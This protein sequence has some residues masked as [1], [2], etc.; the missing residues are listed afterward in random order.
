VQHRIEELAREA[1]ELLDTHRIMLA[2]AESCTGGWISQSL[3]SVAGSSAWFERGFVTYSNAAKEEMLG[4][5]ATTLAN[6]GAVSEDTALAMARGAVDRSRAHMSVAV[7]G[8]AGPTGGSEDKPAGTVWIAWG[9][10]LG[11]AEAEHFAF[12]GG[13]RQV[14]TQAVVAALEGVVRRLR[15]S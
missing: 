4:V 9:Q 8:I 7:T 11:Y 15:A 1:G 12:R 3:T 5:P 6:C 13:R 14:R 10:K 2:T